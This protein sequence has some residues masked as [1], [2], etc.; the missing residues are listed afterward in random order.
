MP[1][2]AFAA[3]L[4]PFDNQPLT[5]RPSFVLQKVAFYRAV[6]RL[7]HYK[8]RLTKTAD[9]TLR[10]G[11]DGQPHSGFSPNNYQPAS[12]F[13]LKRCP[14]G[15]F[16]SRF[17]FILTVF[18]QATCP[19]ETKIKTRFARFYFAFRSVC[20]I[21]TENKLHLGNEN[22]NSFHSLL[23]CIPLGLHYLCIG[24]G[25]DNRNDYGNY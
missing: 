19:S 1:P 16:I 10:A 18:G 21:F 23:F 9:A 22:K 4:H 6:C 17:T 20:I 2:P 14:S 3:R 12:V 5:R 7:P 24:E 15:I 8:R 11:I 13:A 25:N